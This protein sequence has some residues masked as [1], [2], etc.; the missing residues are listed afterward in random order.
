MSNI[1]KT[2]MPFSNENIFKITEK[3]II[4]DVEVYKSFLQIMRKT[5]QQVSWPVF[6]WLFMAA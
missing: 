2:Q 6:G 3:T 1:K 5:N 4:V